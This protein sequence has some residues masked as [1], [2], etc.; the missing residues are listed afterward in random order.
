MVGL[1]FAVGWEFVFVRV[2]LVCGF[3]LG[4]CGCCIAVLQNVVTAFNFWFMI[5]ICAFWFGVLRW[6]LWLLLLCCFLGFV[7][8]ASYLV[9]GLVWQLVFYLLRYGFWFVVCAG[10]LGWWFTGLIWCCLCCW[11]Y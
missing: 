3:A 8:L 6:C 1:R 11:F 10:C 4:L 7:L 2:G 9:C 5:C